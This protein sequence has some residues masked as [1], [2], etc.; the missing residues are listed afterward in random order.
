MQKKKERKNAQV[1]RPD[2]GSP[3]NIFEIVAR[4][5]QAVA[6]VLATSYRR[7]TPA[8]QQ[9]AGGAFRTDLVAAV[10][11]SAEP[12]LLL[13][14][15]PRALVAPPAVPDARLEPAFVAVAVSGEFGHGVL[16]PVAGVECFAA[17]VVA[18]QQVDAS[19]RAEN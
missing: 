9:K 15:R 16:G 7:A 3:Q 6:A 10:G 5:T 11:T 13:G 2:L 4:P 18:G 1:I 14:V 12:A 17:D 19:P 8:A